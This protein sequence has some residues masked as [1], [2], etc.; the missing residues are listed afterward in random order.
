MAEQHICGVVTER[1][2]AEILSLSVKTLQAWRF[3]GRGPRYLKLGGRAV[4]YRMED[5]LDFMNS[6]VVEVDHEIAG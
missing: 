4:R 6:S 2:A 5:L 3:Q 1:K